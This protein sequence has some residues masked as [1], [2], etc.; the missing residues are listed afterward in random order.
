MTVL[1]LIVHPPVYV[2]DVIVY[3]LLSSSPV[4]PEPLELIHITMSPAFNAVPLQFILL[5]TGVQVLRHTKSTVQSH[6]AQVL[7]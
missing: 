3:S 6:R 5:A 7:Q 4:N 1:S 2:T